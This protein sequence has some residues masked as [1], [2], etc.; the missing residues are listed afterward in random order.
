MP[1]KRTKDYGMDQLRG[2]NDKEE[3]EFIYENLF[4]FKNHKFPEQ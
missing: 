1:A 2:H 3:G 4:N